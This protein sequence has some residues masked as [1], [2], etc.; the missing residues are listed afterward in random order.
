MI[1]VDM[2][3]LDS[4]ELIDHEEE[5]LLPGICLDGRHAIDDLPYSRA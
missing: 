1:P 3:Q 5:R 4:S 2:L